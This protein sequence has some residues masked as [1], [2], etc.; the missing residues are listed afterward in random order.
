MDSKDKFDVSIHRRMYFSED[1]GL[2]S[3]P[4]CGLPL[5]KQNCSIFFTS[6]SDSIEVDSITNLTNSHF[7]DVCPV[8]VFDS[9]KIEQA[10]KYV[11]KGKKSIRYSIS[12]IIDFDAIP[13]EKKHVPLGIEE[14]PVPVVKF[15]APLNKSTVVSQKNAGRNGPCSC[16]SSKKYKKCCGR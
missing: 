2:T 3:C 8:V 10:V 7:C 15:L 5:I 14:N 12:G 6:I 4:E 13:E 11:A 9:E 1:C 16:G